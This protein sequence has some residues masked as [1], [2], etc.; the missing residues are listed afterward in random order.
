MRSLISIGL[1]DCNSMKSYVNQI[2]ETGQKLSGLGFNIDDEWIGSLLSA[3]FP[4]R[5]KHSGVGITT[6]AIRTKC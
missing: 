3:E 6:D 5:I 1:E 2:V 4:E